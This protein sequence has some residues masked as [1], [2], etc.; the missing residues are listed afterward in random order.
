MALL[1]AHTDSPALRIKPVSRKFGEGGAYV[2]VGVETYGGVY[3]YEHHVMAILTRVSGGLWHTWFDRDL[4]IAGRAMVR[5]SGKII[6]KLVKVD[7]PILRIPTLAIHL[8]RQQNFEFNKVQ[9][10]SF[11]RLCSQT[12]NKS[13]G[14]AIVPYCCPC[15]KRT[16]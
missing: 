11:T 15:R 9:H 3:L 6:S 1:G 10:P 8:D 4:S 13:T 7:S 5:E 2:Q 16:E 12:A 14:D